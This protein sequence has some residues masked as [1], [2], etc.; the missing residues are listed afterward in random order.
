MLLN[1]EN[2]LTIAL[3]VT[4]LSSDDCPLCNGSISGIF[5]SPGLIQLFIG[6]SSTSSS[7]TSVIQDLAIS[8]IAPL[9]VGQIFQLLWEKGIKWLNKYVNS[10]KVRDEVWG[11]VFRT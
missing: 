6:A 5:V 2:L 11:H 1:K 4:A 3:T 9:V 7:Y 8:V 10:G